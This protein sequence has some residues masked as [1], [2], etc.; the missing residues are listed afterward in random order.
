[1][2]TKLLS[3]ALL[4]LAC[5]APAHLACAGLTFELLY[6]FNPTN[7]GPAYPVAGLAQGSDGN[8]YG[9]TSSGG[10]NGDY[11]TVFQMTPGGVLTTVRSFNGT[12][13]SAPAASLVQGSNG[14]FYG[15]TFAGGSGYNG[16]PDSGN[17]TVFQITTN[18]TLTTLLSFNGTNGSSPFDSLVQGSDG[19]FYG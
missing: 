16:T 8:F 15:T 1:M 12:N 10:T 4:T 3:A 6:Q 19:N 2:K 17:G 5:V 9:T 18:G 11:G 14:N 13:G 7:S